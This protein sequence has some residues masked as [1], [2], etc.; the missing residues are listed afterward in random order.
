M[1][2]DSLVLLQAEHNLRTIADKHDELNRAAETLKIEI[3]GGISTLLGIL[4]EREEVS[5]HQGA[6]RANLL[7]VQ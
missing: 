3:E 5:A 6:F 2:I 1:V 7:T 4:D